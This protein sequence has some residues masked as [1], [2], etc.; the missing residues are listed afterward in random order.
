MFAGSTRMNERCPACNLVFKREAG[1]FLG[2]MYVSYAIAVAAMGFLMWIAWLLLPTWDL[3]ILVLVACGFYLPFVPM[4]FRYSR[5][6]WIHYD[7]WVWPE[8]EKS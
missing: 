7:R 3:G 8:S 6:I 5:V 2:A 1:Y 4:V